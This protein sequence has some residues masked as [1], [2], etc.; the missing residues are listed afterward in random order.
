MR[1]NQAGLPKMPEITQSRIQSPAF[2]VTKMA[3]R[4][5]TKG[6]DCCKCPHLGCPQLHYVPAR[7]DALP[8]SSAWDV[9]VTRKH[10]AWVPRAIAALRSAHA[11]AS[12]D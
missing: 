4:D 11:R 5:N 1:V 3:G 2:G 7:A 12:I 6:A 9:Q 10:I 8:F